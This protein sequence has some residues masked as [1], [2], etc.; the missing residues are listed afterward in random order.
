MKK[1]KVI[2]YTLSILITTNLFSQIIKTCEDS[3]DPLKYVKGEKDIYSEDG[4]NQYIF[5]D[6]LTYLKHGYWIYYSHYNADPNEVYFG[7]YD[8]GKLNGIWKRYNIENDIPIL[9]SIDDYKNGKLD[10]LSVS[11]DPEY[12]VAFV[13]LFEN[14]QFIEY[15]YSKEDSLISPVLLRDEKRYSNRIMWH[16]KISLE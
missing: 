4:C 1:G 16:N 10:G 5:L 2:F 9:V 8:N 11:F 14:S 13:A 7:Y 12:T 15:L 6:S 3:F